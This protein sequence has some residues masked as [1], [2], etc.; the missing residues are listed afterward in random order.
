MA[1]KSPEKKSCGKNVPALRRSICLGVGGSPEKL[2]T[3]KL[4]IIMQ[5]LCAED[6]EEGEVLQIH[7]GERRGVNRGV[8][9]AKRKLAASEPKSIRNPP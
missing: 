3:S 6:G 2:T 8:Q 4:R 7:D 1:Q 5:E 9:F